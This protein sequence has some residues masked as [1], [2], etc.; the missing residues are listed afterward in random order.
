MTRVLN[1]VAIALTLR[2]TNWTKRAMRFFS[3]N[4]LHITRQSR[5]N[6]LRQPR[7]RHANIRRK[8]RNLTNR[9]HA[10][11]RAT[12][13]NNINAHTD[14]L[15]NG[16][17]HNTLHRSQRRRVLR[18]LSLPTVEVCSVIGDGESIARHD[19]LRSGMRASVRKEIARMEH[20]LRFE[21][22]QRSID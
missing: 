3:E 4:H 14:Q 16:F 20:A 1:R 21:V 19:Q 12:R 15:R 11:I 6:R 7:H 17:F 2:V 10:T 9:M 8:R 13:T 18:F 22:R 5:G